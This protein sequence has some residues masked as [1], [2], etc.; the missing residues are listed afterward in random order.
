MRIRHPT[1]IPMKALVG[2][3]QAGTFLGR[4]STSFVSGLAMFTV[5]PFS[6]TLSLVLSLTELPASEAGI[7][8]AFNFSLRT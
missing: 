1:K 8:L 7:M 6:M 5:K 2:A 3:S 4:R